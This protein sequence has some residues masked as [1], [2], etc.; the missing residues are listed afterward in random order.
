MLKQ[1]ETVARNPQ[2]AALESPDA[3]A[4][5]PGKFHALASLSDRHKQL[6]QAL[7]EARAAAAE[8]ARQH[9]ALEKQIEADAASL[10]PGATRAA[11]LDHVHALADKRRTLSEF[12]TRTEDELGLVEDYQS[13][14]TLALA[15]RRTVIHRIVRVFS[16]IL[17]ILMAVFT[18]GSLIRNFFER[19]GTDRRRHHHLRLIVEL[20]IQVGGILLVLLIIF[21]P[22]RQFG[23]I[24][25]LTTAGLTV[26]LKDFIVAF[27]GW[28]VLMGKNGMR[29][30][31][32]VEINGVSGEVVEITLFRT[33]LLETGNWSD[34]GQPTGRRVSFM[35]GF[36]IEGQYFN[37]STAGQWLWDD[38]RVTVPAGEDA[39]NKVDEIRA[40][41][42]RT[43]STNARLAEEERKKATRAYGATGFSAASSIDLRPVPEGIQ[44]IVRYITRAP[45]RFDMRTR[46]YQDVINILH[47]G[48]KA[49]QDG[50]S[51]AAA[52]GSTIQDTNTDTKE[53]KPQ[54]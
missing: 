46:L 43:T 36:A 51:Q 13:W 53:D 34:A 16:V 38:L 5:L 23:T 31:D 20:A 26:V 50:A 44:V 27:I 21:G 40:V 30:G 45:Q 3:L 25:G 47:Y 24:L 2:V 15:Q 1:S 8:L 4:T 14:D 48:Q 19:E 12:G 32:W 11:T 17:V 49:D 18:A 42:E 28:F 7:A 37:F 33:V 29:I 6:Q 52:H 35:N 22:P 9:D 39:Y 10:P 41:V 54:P